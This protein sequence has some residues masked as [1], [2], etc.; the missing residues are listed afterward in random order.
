VDHWLSRRH[1]GLEE[2]EEEEEEEEGT[3]DWK[4]S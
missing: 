2:E 4:E 3:W 1:C